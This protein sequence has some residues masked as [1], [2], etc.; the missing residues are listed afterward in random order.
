L[1]NLEKYNKQIPRYTSYPTVPYWENN[2]TE[3]LWI[4]EIK[5]SFLKNN[6]DGISLYVHLP[7]CE[8]LCTYCACNT[9]ITV[10]HKV[11]EPYI[12]AL[13]KEWQMYRNL[14]CSPP[15]IK[16]IHLGGGTPTFFSANNLKKLITEILK[17][18]EISQNHDF[19][20]E[21]HPS[22]TTKEHLQT[23]FNLGFKRVSFGIQDFDEKVQLAINRFQTVDE[24][25]SVVNE[26]R[27]IGYN[28]INF[29]LVYGLPF[30]TPNSV[31][32]TINEVIKL[33]PDRIAYYSYAH[34][35]WLKPGQR[36][37]TEV[38]I[39]NGKE[40]KILYTIGEQLFTEHN[41]KDIGMDH[42]ALPND[43]LFVAHK[44]KKL[45]RNFMGYTT[46][47]TKLLVGLGC[48][49]ISDSWGAFSQN[50]KDVETY[51][52]K[53]NSNLFPIQKGHILTTYD[54]KIK[55]LIIDIMCKDE[56]KIDNSFEFNHESFMELLKDNLIDINSNTV[57]ITP[58][59]KSFLRNIA[60]VFDKR[61]WDSNPTTNTFSLAI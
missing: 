40:K 56:F 43:E 11:E 44:T 38:D 20:F 8:S 19:S 55:K 7:Y 35:P 13:L 22:N 18:C 25:N 17:D 16:E 50:I 41:Y 2:L 21:G 34:V 33:K 52:E 47:S 39:P 12:N 27:N 53:I 36:R 57:V 1:K 24:V 3:T 23:L 29:D 58:L 61:F 42:F 45:H 6:K 37:Y 54:L 59:G 28:S 10:N 32:S 31:L 5:N 9:R 49:A 14:F 26:A 15:L 4:D 51:I 46:N 48:S 30:Q 60:L